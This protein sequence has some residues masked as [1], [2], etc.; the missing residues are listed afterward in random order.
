MQEFDLRSKL[1]F[2]LLLTL[3]LVFSGCTS[4]QARKDYVSEAI[5]LR[6]LIA[7]SMNEYDDSSYQEKVKAELSKF[8]VAYGDSDPEEK[9]SLAE[10]LELYNDSISIALLQAK[11]VDMGGGID[12][13]SVQETANLISQA[14]SA[15]D[16]AIREASEGT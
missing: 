15:I 7:N 1:V 6:E 9:Y 3:C 11:A 13:E 16:E 5:D 14:R 4:S 12:R 2:S 10:R 8:R